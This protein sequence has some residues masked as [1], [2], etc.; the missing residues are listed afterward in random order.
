MA[1]NN[2]RPVVRALRKPAL[3]KTSRESEKENAEFDAASR[4][5]Y[6]ENLQTNVADEASGYTAS[7]LQTAEKYA[8]LSGMRDMAIAGKHRDVA[9]YTAEDLNKKF[10]SS[11]G[12]SQ[13]QGNLSDHKLPTDI[14]S[15]KDTTKGK[16]HID[17]SSRITNG[18][19]YVF[20]RLLEMRIPPPLIILE[21]FCVSTC[22]SYLLK[23]GHAPLKFGRHLLIVEKA[24]GTFSMM[25]LFYLWS[26]N[27][28]HYRIVRTT[29]LFMGIVA[30][31][32][33]ATAS[34]AIIT[35]L[36]WKYCT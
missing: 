31:P 3:P 16:M 6:L 32:R 26:H 8:E 19:N 25:A 20:Q 4:R 9:D 11:R 21:V 23:S 12:K 29:G 10:G 35:I 34:A 33:F 7:L 28:K 27:M 18:V 36:R 24:C 17:I 22:L 15:R 2:R 14:G 1:A 13:E 30:C 5:H